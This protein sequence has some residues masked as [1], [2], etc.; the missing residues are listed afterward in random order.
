MIVTGHVLLAS[1]FPSHALWEW[2]WGR[3]LDQSVLLHA[4]HDTHLAY[5]SGRL[6]AQ[7]QQMLEQLG[8]SGI[9]YHM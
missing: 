6:K 3:D 7:T 5:P 2:G 8:G 1:D 4:V 9:H